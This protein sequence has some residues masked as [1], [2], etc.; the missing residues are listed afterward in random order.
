[1]RQ[2]EQYALHRQELPKVEEAVVEVVEVVMMEVVWPFQSVAYLVVV[3]DC[4]LKQANTL[5]EA[6]STGAVTSQH[7]MVSGNPSQHHSVVWTMM[8]CQ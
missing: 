1:M 5:G 6:V 8:A 4:N 3:H 2:V 7:N